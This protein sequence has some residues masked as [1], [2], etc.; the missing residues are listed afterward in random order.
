MNQST[1]PDNSFIGISK[2]NHELCDKIVDFYKDNLHLETNVD[3]RNGK[4]SQIGVPPEWYGNPFGEYMYALKQSLKEYNNT[5]KIT[6]IINAY[7]IRENYVIQ[8]YNKGEGFNRWH[9][10]RGSG[11]P[12]CDRLFVFMTYLND[13][14]DG[15]TEFMYHNNVEAIKG[16]TIIWPAE[17]THTHRAIISDTSEKYIIT[18]WYSLMDSNQSA[19]YDEEGNMVIDEFGNKV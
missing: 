9:W 15:G 5:W 2:I 3:D 4:F 8:R 14:P 13:V 6:N 17:W 18:G 16:N 1:S 7:K 19:F 10:E 11:K 12:Q